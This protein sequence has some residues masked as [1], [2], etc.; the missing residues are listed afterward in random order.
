MFSNA[1]AS[2]AEIKIVPVVVL[3]REA[4]AVPLAEALCA[5]GLNA[6]EVTF[7]TQAAEASIHAISKRFPNMTV[8][9]GTLS[10]VEQAQRALDAGASFFVS[11][12]FHRGVTEFAL[13]RH[14][15][16]YPGVCTPTELML[17][18][19]YGLPL[20]KFFPAAQF[21]GLDTIKALAGPFPQMK[22][23][24]TGGVGPGNVLDYLSFDKVIACG[25]S[26]MV[27]PELIRAGD[28]ARIQ[29]LTNEAVELVKG[30]KRA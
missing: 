2:L 12:G 9:A 26:W 23:M 14:V 6:A 20:A 15:P 21:G 7:R 11:A 10:S 4:D 1:L 8:G 24:P 28:F 27:K 22:F 17:L 19:E 25:G 3:D 16:I 5:G 30:A 13:E 18:L 29:T